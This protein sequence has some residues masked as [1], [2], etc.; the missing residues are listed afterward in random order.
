ME[1]QPRAAQQVANRPP[2][3]Y[4]RP[5]LALILQSLNNDQQIQPPLMIDDQDPK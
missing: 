2:I 5:F 1:T 4:R 3:Q